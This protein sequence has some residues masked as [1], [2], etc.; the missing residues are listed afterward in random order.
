MAWGARGGALG[1]NSKVRGGVG[2]PGP[3]GIKERLWKYILVSM[4]YLHK[5]MRGKMCVC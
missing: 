1:W 5:D 4:I 3:R 2:Y